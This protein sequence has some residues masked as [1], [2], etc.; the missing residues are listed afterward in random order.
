MTPSKGVL[1]GAVATLV[2]LLILSSSLTFYYYGQ[3]QQNGAQNRKYADELSSALASY[4][5]LSNSFNSSLSDYGRTLSLL[6]MALANLNTSAPAYVNASQALSSLWDSYQRLS[7][8]GGRRALVYS[9][10]L[11]VDFG[12]GTRKWFNSTSIQP[13][14][15]GYLAT[16]VLLR[17]GVQATW[18]PQYGEHLVTGIDGVS[19]TSARSWFFWD[20]AGAWSLAATGADGLQVNNGTSIAWTLCGYDAS[21]NPTCSP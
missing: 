11:L 18:Y 13:G 12:N 8:S 6:S 7:D 17:G 15:N 3:N 16:L 1:Y 21:F 9:A 5:S 2:A 20:F 14:W 4:R 10:H 19:Q